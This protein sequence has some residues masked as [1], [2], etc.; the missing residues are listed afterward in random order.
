MDLTYDSSIPL[1]NDSGIVQ[2]YAIALSETQIAVSD[3][4]N[5]QI[6]LFNIDGM[7]I[8]KFGSIGEDNGQFALPSGIAFSSDRI[9]VTDRD[10]YRIQVFDLDG[11]FIGKFDALND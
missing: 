1:N 5:D 11:E 2:P 6:Q 7:F 8:K 10:N 9:F 3:R 4:Y